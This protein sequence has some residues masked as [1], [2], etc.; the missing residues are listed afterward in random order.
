MSDQ[1]AVVARYAAIAAAVA[2]HGDLD[3]A[4]R[5]FE[6]LPDGAP[7]RARLAAGLIEAIFKTGTVPGPVPTRAM[8]GLLAAADSDPP[9]TPGWPRTRVAAEV[10]LLAQ[11]DEDPA[12]NLERLERL[13]AEHPDDAVLQPLFTSARTAL[14]FAVGV[15]RADAGA[16]VHLPEEI[17][18]FL[19]GLPP[20]LANQPEAAVLTRMAGMLADRRYDPAVIQHTIDAL[21]DGPVRAAFDEASPGLATFAGLIDDDSPRPSDEEMAAFVAHSERPGLAPADRALL[22]SQAG[23]TAL[24]AGRETDPARLE[25]GLDQLRKALALIGPDDPMRVVHLG[26]LATALMHRHELSGDGRALREAA[27]I[28]DE[29]RALAGGPHHPQW[30]IISEMA[31]QI[32]RHLGDRPAAH[33]VAL[34]GLRGRVWQVLVQPDL[35][36]ATAAVRDAGDEAIEVARQC[37]AATDPAAAITALDAGRGLALFAATVTGSLADRL[38]EAGEIALADRWRVAASTGDPAALPTELRRDV[39]TALSRTSATGGLLDPPGYAEI[40]QALTDLE[41]D[42]LVYLVP[43]ERVRPGHAVIAPVVGPPSFLTL[44]GLTAEMAPRI[45]EYLTVL[46]RHVVDRELDDAEEQ[47][48]DELTERLADI[49]RWAWDAVM[50]PLIET[51][52]PRLPATAGR[53]YRIVLIPMGDLSRVPWQAARRGDGRYAVELIAVSQAA[54][55]RMLVRSASLAPVPRSGTGLIVGDPEAGARVRALP[56]ARL[57]AYAIRQ[58]FYPGARYLGRRPDGTPSRSGGGTSAEVRSWLT[59]PGPVSGGMLHLA[60][61]GFVRTGGPRA[62]AYLQL[63]TDERDTGQLTA[64]ELIA[65]LTAVPERALGLVVLAACQT[66]LSLS[67]FDEA[68]SLGTAF[69]AGGA[70]TVLSSQWNVPDSATSALMFMV[71]RNLRVAGRPPWAALRDAQLWMLDP[72]RQIPDDM[73]AVLRD[74]LAGA[75]LAAVASWA[76]F[77]HG[78]R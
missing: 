75:D 60:C 76:A 74:R 46:S 69:L 65:L 63:A 42:A 36:A 25:L 49:G 6:Q 7:G 66:G 10:L 34:D 30:Q 43:G 16:M 44:L 53:P 39:M 78:G 57:E 27:G 47:D 59:T 51:Y 32:G 13:A 9:A 18:E 26:T 56:A 2:G 73:P 68:Y 21:P 24:R 61:H 15:R 48:D 70:R 64:E 33:L 5:D 62:T 31:G 28:V 55:A 35:V 17:A 50:R 54:S 45:D 23:L 41:A 58:F 3:A 52:L 8:P 22:H 29:A 12:G 4:V 1:D 40:Q 72:K 20:H 14:R 67:G 37:L 77:V 19:A 71:H 11:P 38:A